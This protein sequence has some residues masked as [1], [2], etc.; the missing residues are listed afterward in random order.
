MYIEKK[1]TT[2]KEKEKMYIDRPLPKLF[3]FE[4][5]KVQCHSHAICGNFIASDPYLKETQKKSAVIRTFAEKLN[6]D[7]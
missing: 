1:T 6:S 2:A 7:P 5:C 4:K 3:E